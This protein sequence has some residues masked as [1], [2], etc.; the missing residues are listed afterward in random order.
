MGLRHRGGT[1]ALWRLMTGRGRMTLSELGAALLSSR[2]RV[3][4]PRKHV[5][6]EIAAVKRV[7]HG[8]P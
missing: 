5:R 4:I 3:R 6:T 1:L 8:N 2:D 7:G